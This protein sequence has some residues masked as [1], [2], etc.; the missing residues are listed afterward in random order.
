MNTSCEMCLMPFAKDTGVRESEQYC[1]ICYHDGQLQ[2]ESL[3]L[4]EFKQKSY[5]GM[6]ESGMGFLKAKF[7]TAMI[8]FA[9]YWKD[10]K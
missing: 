5:D 9:P 6:R 8:G 4:A 1:S 7:F 2:G 3:T 10:K